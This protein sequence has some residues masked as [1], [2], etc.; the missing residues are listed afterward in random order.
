MILDYATKPLQ[1]ALFR[2]LREQK[3]GSG[4]GAKSCARK[5][6]ALE[7][8]KHFTVVVHYC[9]EVDPIGALRNEAS[10]IEFGGVNG[11]K[12]LQHWVRVTTSLTDQVEDGSTTPALES[13]KYFTIFISGGTAA[14]IC[15]VFLWVTRPHPTRCCALLYP[16]VLH[17]KRLSAPLQPTLPGEAETDSMLL[18][19][20]SVGTTLQG[21]IYYDPL[22][23]W[24]RQQR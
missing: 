24:T 4:S 21:T 5:D 3:N 22:C 18:S 8:H 17:Y 6:Q 13:R 15:R 7:S 2:K 10:A 14:D 23:L 9:S 11:S 1:G 16:T 12:S 20:L 19:S